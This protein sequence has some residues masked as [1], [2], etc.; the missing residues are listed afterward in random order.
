[1]HYKILIEFYSSIKYDDIKYTPGQTYL[2]NW[3]LK[4]Q[5]PSKILTYPFRLLTEQQM[6]SWAIKV[7]A[8]D[9]IKVIGSGINNY[10]K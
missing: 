2:G 8:G 10:E 1:M 5:T 4:S 7:G 9:V 6:A 3:I